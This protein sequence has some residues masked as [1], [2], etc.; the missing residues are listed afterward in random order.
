MTRAKGTPMAI[1]RSLTTLLNF[2][3]D[4]KPLKTFNSF[5]D[6]FSLK[7]ALGGTAAAAFAYQVVQSINSVADLITETDALSRRSGIAFEQINNLTRAA[8]QLGRLDAKSFQAVL[9]NISD[10][11]LDALRG[12]TRLRE[13]QNG[14][15]RSGVKFN[16]FDDTGRVADALTV[17]E[18]LVTAINQLPNQRLRIQAFEEIFKEDGER[19]DEIFKNGYQSFKA[20]ADTFDP[21]SKVLADQREFANQYKQ[22]LQQIATEFNNV[23][24]KFVVTFAPVISGLVHLLGKSVEL[25]GIYSKEF[26]QYIKDPI[27]NYGKTFLLGNEEENDWAPFPQAATASP[28]QVENIFQVNLAPGTPAEQGRQIAD[29]A[30]GELTRWFDTEVQ[31]VMSNNPQVE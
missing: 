26:D 12:G 30:A 2:Q 4:L 22:D 18:R 14:L 7:F 23:I 25:Y 6:K 17:F 3:V 5:L 31:K 15:A 27:L 29:T 1:V 16:P 11:T 28:I 10:A 20:L 9:R 21:I 19:L 24:E 8:Q 13:I